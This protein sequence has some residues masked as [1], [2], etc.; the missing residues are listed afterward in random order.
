M[1]RQRHF[2]HEQRHDVGGYKFDG[3]KHPA[4]DLPPD[5]VNLQP[6]N[7]L[8][9]AES[10]SGRGSRRLRAGGLKCSLDHEEW[11]YIAGMFDGEGS[12]VQ[13]GASTSS[14]RRYALTIA[15]KDPTP[16]HRILGLVGI[17]AIHFANGTFRY[18]LTGQRAVF[19]FLT[20]MQP[21]LVVKLDKART[22]LR[23]MDAAYGSELDV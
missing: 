8:G 5:H 3:Y 17:G 12:V 14:G 4:G 2:S 23:E 22:A 1:G 18:H 9:S 6:S 21:Y 7:L 20:A 11:P 13:V 19:Q 15:Q 16:L 10:A